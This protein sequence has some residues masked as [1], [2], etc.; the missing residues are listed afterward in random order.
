MFAKPSSG[1]QLFI[2]GMSTAM[3]GLLL[4]AELLSPHDVTLGAILLV[5]IVISCLYLDSRTTVAIVT[6]A[7]TTRLVAAALGDIA[8][9]QVG[10]ECMSYTAVAVVAFTYV[11]RKASTPSG[12]N[13]AGGVV[14]FPSPSPRPA[15]LD[16]SSLS[17]REREVL[18]M[19]LQGLTAAQ[20]G[21]RL[22]IGR[23]TVETHLGRTY[24]KLGVH[25]KRDL[26]ALLFDS[27]STR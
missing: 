11:A 1:G 20:I 2:T 14:A 22:C 7:T 4:A 23:R 13:M 6:L 27:N 5:P 18:E 8:F 25:T 24:S 16:A 12:M 15:D 3:I 19:A 10:L 26:I 21:A 9:G 17:A